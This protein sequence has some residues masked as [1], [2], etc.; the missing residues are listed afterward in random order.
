MSLFHVFFKP[1]TADDMRISDWSSDVC[2]SDLGWLGLSID[3]DANAANALCIS[4]RE[5]RV[6]VLVIPTDE[7]RMIAD[8]TLAVLRSE[9]R[10]GCYRFADHRLVTLP[11]CSSRPRLPVLVTVLLHHGQRRTLT[12]AACRIGKHWLSTFRLT[13]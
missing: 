7:E 2:S 11:A 9:S 12:P 1:K 6:K 4:G 3:D 13:S 5:S 8:H 10:S